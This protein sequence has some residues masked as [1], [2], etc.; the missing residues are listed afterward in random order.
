[1]TVA[2]VTHESV[3]QHRSWAI[4]EIHRVLDKLQAG[5][6][7]VRLD[8]GFALDCTESLAQRMDVVHVVP[9]QANWIPLFKAYE[10]ARAERRMHHL[11]A[12]HNDIGVRF[13]PLSDGKMVDYAE[14]DTW[15]AARCDTHV[16]VYDGRDRGSVVRYL[17]LV[18]GIQPTIIIDPATQSTRLLAPKGAPCTSTS[19]STSTALSTS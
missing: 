7:L 1:M 11:L 12:D 13:L 9:A 15:L 19:P 3:T 18:M 14:R 4:D 8:P 6:I 16:C 17:Q 5:E 2:L 10:R